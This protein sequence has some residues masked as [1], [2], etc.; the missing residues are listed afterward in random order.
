MPRWL[1]RKGSQIAA[2]FLTIAALF[3]PLPSTAQ[4]FNPKSFKLANGMTVVVIENNRA[5]IVT[6]MV[7]YKVGAADEPPGKS[8]IAHFLEHLMFKGTA[9]VP[10]GEFSKRI[11]SVG[12]RDNAF[13]SYDYT[14]YFQNVPREQLEFAMRLESD[15][16]VNLRLTDDV[17]YPERDVIREERRQVIENRPAALLREQAQAA[18]Y[19]NHPYR[20]PVIGWDHEIAQLTREDAVAWYR[21]WYT[22]SNAVLIVAGDVTVE[23]VRPLAEKY[24][25]GI[26]ARPV[27]PRERPQEPPPAAARRVELKDPRVRQP[28]LSL[29]WLAPSYKGGASEHAYALQVLAEILGGGATSRL[30]RALVIEKQLA[31]SA[32]A[33]YEP[34]MLDRSS[35]GA[36]ASL[37][38]GAE[39]S[40]LE[41]ALQAELRQFLEK[42]V[43]DDEV[44]RAKVRMRA[45]AVYAR[46]NLST[47]AQV[48][49]TAL[50]TGQTI[51]DV[52]A[53]PARIA[54]VTPAQVM[55]AARYVLQPERSVTGVLLEQPGS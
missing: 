44:E 43:S 23:T 7:W 5:P 26:E 25:G 15:R 8:G 29:S 32:G 10:A 9:T 33:W 12:G 18:L 24:Y 42:G 40:A 41:E 48:I 51:E 54:V 47:G 39:I 31:T 14:G 3:G 4:V 16:M 36:S 38:P 21:K 27:P 20:L 37:R 11:A 22:P 28:M 6:H 53:W 19:L 35:F 45:A 13:T 17:V 1:Q 46:D 34:D 30:Y 49:G 50:T 55:A 52:E 2:V